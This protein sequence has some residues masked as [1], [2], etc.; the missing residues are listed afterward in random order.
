MKLFSLKLFLFE[1]AR[2][3]CSSHLIDLNWE[4]KPHL[5]DNVFD[6]SEGCSNEANIVQR[7][8]M[9]DE[10]FSLADLPGADHTPFG[11]FKTSSTVL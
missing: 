10:S 9:L 4:I 2:K 1:F 11:I 5:H 7:P 6:E 3:K 8:S